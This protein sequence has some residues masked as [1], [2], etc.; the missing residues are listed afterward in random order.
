MTCAEYGQV[1]LGSLLHALETWA[2]SG[3][4]RANLISRLVRDLR[5]W[6]LLHVL[7]QHSFGGNSDEACIG[8][9]TR[10]FSYVVPSH[11]SITCCKWQQPYQECH[12]GGIRDM[13]P[14]DQCTCWQHDSACQQGFV[15]RNLKHKCVMSHRNK[16]MCKGTPSASSR[17]RKG[18]HHVV[19]RI[20]HEW[21]WRGQAL[22][23]C[24]FSSAQRQQIHLSLTVCKKQVEGED[25]KMVKEK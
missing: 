21:K 17:K 2:N 1:M 20:V 10:I 23:P 22:L 8:R 6:D 12:N 15:I 7:Q 25:W 11:A 13:P 19:G 4:P 16:D 5:P 18:E 24:S 9:F 3:T 14:H